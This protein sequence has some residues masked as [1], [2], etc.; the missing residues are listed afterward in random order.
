MSGSWWWRRDFCSFYCFPSELDAKSRKCAF[1][2]ENFVFDVDSEVPSSC[3]EVA[4]AADSTT[5]HVVDLPVAAAAAADEGEA[6]VA[7][8]EMKH[9]LEGLVFDQ[10]SV[11]SSRTCC[12]ARGRPSVSSA[13]PSK[14]RL[15]VGS[16]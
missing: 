15:A 7:T 4:V 6:L 13:R 2:A 5:K 16:T 8:K 1:W 9:P 14:T 12:E 10:R 3:A 11:E